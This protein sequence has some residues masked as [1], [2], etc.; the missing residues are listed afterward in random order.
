MKK[1]PATLVALVVLLAAC[2]DDDTATTAA[3]STTAPAPSTTE[4]P[5]TTT[6]PPTTAAETTT[7]VDP[8]ASLAEAMIGFTGTFS[9]EWHNTTF[10]SRG[11]ITASIAFDA[12]AMAVILEVDLGGF[13]F[14]ASDPDP[15][16][17]AIQVADLDLGEGGAITA[18]VT[19]ATF[20]D[21]EIGFAGDVISVEGADVPGDRI[22]TIA[23]TGNMTADGADLQYVLEFEGGGGA[24]GT[25]TLERTP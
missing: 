10:D 14:G 7:T 12:M 17:L 23:V 25:A 4:A 9:G 3:P 18:T 16:E 21:L 20:G 8:L 1:I 24:E 11:P 15:E 13:V 6:A 22:A 5:P 2:G 19:S